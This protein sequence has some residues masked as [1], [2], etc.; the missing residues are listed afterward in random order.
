MKRRIMNKFKSLKDHVY[1]YIADQILVGNLRPEEKI[2]ENVICEELSISRT[3]VREA[4]IQL[5]SEGILDNVPRKGF[6]VKSLSEEEATELY[7]IIG[8]LDGLAAR[9]AC[10]NLTEKDFKDMQ[11]YIDSMTLTIEAKNYEMYLTQQK[12]F[13]QVYIDKCGNNALIEEIDKLKNKFLKKS[14]L[15]DPEGEISR[16]L[17]ATNAEH[18]EILEL[19]KE[20]KAGEVSKYL[21][22]I[23]WAPENAHFDLMSLNE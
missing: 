17:T 11:F 6:V 14:Y 13:H 7:V 18:Q 2:N 20:Y 22:E 19:F 5:S 10:P 21:A 1:D 12:I 3:P 4:L 8:D 9:L 15:D 23:H 16:T